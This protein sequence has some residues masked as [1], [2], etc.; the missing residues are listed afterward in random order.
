L[1]EAFSLFDADGDG[2]ITASELRNVMKSLG[3]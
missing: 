3:R 2:N 1:K